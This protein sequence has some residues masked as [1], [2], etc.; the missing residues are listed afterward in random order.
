MKNILR[1]IPRLPIPLFGST[2]LRLAFEFGV[3][4]SEVAKGMS[5]ELTPE[6]VARAEGI[7]VNQATTKSDTE[8]AG[9]MNACALAAF[10]PEEKV[11]Q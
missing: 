4:M 8:M 9:M 2:K 6:I 3:I 1:R 7:V 11:V 10:E 5:V